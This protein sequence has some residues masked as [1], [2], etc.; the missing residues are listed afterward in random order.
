MG[1]IAEDREHYGTS[2]TNEFDGAWRPYKTFRGSPKIS[3]L[4]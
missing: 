2:A 4:S 1:E 3:L